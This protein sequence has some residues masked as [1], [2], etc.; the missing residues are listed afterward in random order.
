MKLPY[1]AINAHR[2]EAGISVAAFAR[3]NGIDYDV[4]WNTF[5]RGTTPFE[6]NRPGFR[7]YYFAHEA[8]V[9]AIAKRL[10]AKA[11]AKKSRRRAIS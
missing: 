3:D 10:V 6:H 7:R 11:K 2:I 1:Q 8:E 9:S 5:K 4:V